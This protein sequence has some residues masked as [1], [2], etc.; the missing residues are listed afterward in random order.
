MG[1]PF[2]INH[3]YAYL[4]GGQR[5]LQHCYSTPTDTDDTLTYEVH[6][7]PLCDYVDLE[8]VVST[9]GASQTGWVLTVQAGTGTSVTATP[10]YLLEGSDV[11]RL[12]APWD[13]ND[14]GLCTITITYKHISPRTI[15]IYDVPR[16]SIASTEGGVHLHDGTYH[17]VGL[18]A[19]AYIADS[20]T[21][22]PQA[23]VQEIEDAWSAYRPQILALAL[24]ESDKLTTTSGTFED[25]L[26]YD[27]RYK[28]RSRKSTASTVDSDW[29]IYAAVSGGA[30]YELKVTSSTDSVTLTGL[31]TAATTRRLLSGMA[32]DATGYDTDIAVQGRISSGSGT[33]SVYTI[34]GILEA[35]AP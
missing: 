12:R 17:R 22:G 16:A 27:I 10:G 20:A 5:V 34:C 21:A 32:I 31:T 29:V 30:T 26:S 13:S 1:S 24:S 19:D 7:H 35:D 18:R 33:L 15:S 2:M 25:L 9:A 4:L 3:V 8:I 14:T 6:R 11:I 28:A 23:L